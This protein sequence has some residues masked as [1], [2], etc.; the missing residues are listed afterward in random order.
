MRYELYYWSMIQGRGEFV[1]LALAEAGAEYIDIARR[2]FASPRCD[3][4][5]TVVGL[6][7]D[8]LICRKN[9]KI[10]MFE[11]A[12]ARLASHFLG[13]QNFPRSEAG[14]RQLQI[15]RQ[16]GSELRRHGINRLRPR[17]RA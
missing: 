4:E 7:V 8:V 14:F 9:Q 3:S 1:R 15:V 16:S 13:T 6:C 2:K 12:L 10:R 5:R 17:A 11:S